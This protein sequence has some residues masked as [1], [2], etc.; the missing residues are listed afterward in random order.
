MYQ[1]TQNITLPRHLF[2]DILL[3]LHKMNKLC[4]EIDHYQAMEEVKN[5]DTTQY[6]NVEDFL[7]SL[8]E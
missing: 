6:N 5:N 1:D 2:D 8:D 4:E 7:D 3:E